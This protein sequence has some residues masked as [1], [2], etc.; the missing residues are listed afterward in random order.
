MDCRLSL[1]VATSGLFCLQLIVVLLTNLVT[2]GFRPPVIVSLMNI[3][4]QK[5]GI[6]CGLFAVA[7]LTSLANGV[8]VTKVKFDQALMR[9]HLVNCID[10]KGMTPFPSSSIDTMPTNSI[11][12]TL[13]L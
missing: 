8:D 11:I 9:P 6:D 2:G 3:G 1:S 5:G 10:S 4:K 12:K 13:C 7:V